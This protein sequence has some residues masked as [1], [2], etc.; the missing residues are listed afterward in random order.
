MTDL[1]QQRTP[2]VVFLLLLLAADG[3][4]ISK[5]YVFI[6]M[7]AYALYDKTTQKQHTL[8]SETPVVSTHEAD[9]TSTPGEEATM[10]TSSAS[11]RTVVVDATL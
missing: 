1:K 3:F 7:L 10:V 6:S 8:L 4:K 2:L 11:G 5:W 9:D